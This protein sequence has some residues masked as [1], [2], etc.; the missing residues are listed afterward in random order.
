MPPTRRRSKPISVVEG[1]RLYEQT[2]LHVDHIAAMMGLGKKALYN[3]VKAW[4]WRLRRP[5]IPRN[6][7]PRKPDE[8]FGET[9]LAER[10]TVDLAATAARVLGA[11]EGELDAITQI[12]R[13]LPPQPSEER[14]RMQRMLA[15][16]ARTLQELARLK[17]LAGVQDANDR[18]P[19]D[20]DEFARILLRR[21]DE[22][23]A[24]RSNRIPDGAKPGG[25]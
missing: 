9:T 12:L 5:R 14:E 8:V 17:S 20:P 2:N 6:D 18:G 10:A 7:P 22:F 19:D 21:L 15:S 3:R 16:L 13:L 1:R 25:A 23:R 24:R 11:V 4:G